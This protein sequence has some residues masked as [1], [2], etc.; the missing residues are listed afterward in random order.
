MTSLH[1]ASLHSTLRVLRV[2]R[3]LVLAGS[4]AAGLAACDGEG[5][6]AEAP[7]PQEPGAEAVGYYCG[8]TVADHPGPKG[9]VFLEGRDDPLWFSSA[10]DLLAFTMLPDESKAVAAL[11]VNDMSRAQDWDR[12]D[13]GSWVRADEA[14]YVVGSDRRGGMG[15]LETVPFSDRAAA[16]RFRAQHGGSLFAFGEVPEEYVLGPGEGPPARLSEQPAQGGHDGHVT[17]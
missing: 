10:R 5:Q 6:V 17:Q 1:S 7:P 12:P 14:V 16:E 15:A 3:A 11:Y 4:L 8:M 9:Q 13:P 2:L